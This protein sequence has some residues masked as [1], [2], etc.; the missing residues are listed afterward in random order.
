MNDRHKKNFRNPPNSSN[1]EDL[2]HY[3]WNHGLGN[4][5]DSHGDP[6][7]WNADSM[8]SAFESVH[9]SVDKRAIQNWRS[10]R[11]LPSRR[12]IH[13]LCRIISGDDDAL[14]KL[15]SDKLIASL[16]KRKKTS[17]KKSENVIEATSP[18][19]AKTIAETATKSPRQPQITKRVFMLLPL[20][21]VAIIIGL[22][23]LNKISKSSVNNTPA[24]TG[25]D[26]ITI[27]KSIA[28]FPFKV[29]SDDP[30]VQYFSEGITEETLHGLSQVKDIKLAS[31]RAVASLETRLPSPEAV[32]ATLGVN[33]I[34]DGSVRS[35]GVRFKVSTRLIKTSD[36]SIYWSETFDNKDSNIFDIQEN[37]STGIVTALNIHLSPEERKRMFNFGTRDVEAYR[38]YLKGRHLLKYWH[39]TKKGDDIW[40]A[41]AEFD[42]AVVEDP[43]MSKAW[44]HMADPY[45][46]FAAD[47]IEKPPGSLNVMV[48][49]TVV[50][51]AKHI[52]FVLSKAEETAKN[53]TNKTQARLN[54]IFFSDDWVGLKDATIRFSDLSTQERGELEWEFGPVSL[55]LLG[56]EKRL[57]KLMDDRVLKYDSGNGTAHAYVA[58]SHLVQNKFAAAEN[59]LKT[60]RIS[61]FSSRIN[62]TT[63]YLLYAQNKIEELEGFLDEVS[64]ISPMLEDYFSALI[65]HSKGDSQNA[66]SI[67]LGS[68][69]LAD[70]KIHLALALNHIGQTDKAQKHLKVITDQPL[71]TS[72]L[73]VILSYGAACGSNPLP[74][75]LK[76]DEKLMRANINKLACVKI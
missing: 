21:A 65:T 1:F 16:M 51:A 43:N 54:R 45:Y 40:R 53:E 34:L 55:V 76:L 17:F 23:S 14:K 9:R 69:H 2:F 71:G 19:S 72:M 49:N 26:P 44:F 74:P 18:T 7:P 39:E 28:I 68:K 63:A 25:I 20:M 31:R 61:S 46:H 29:F 52:E 38:H 10:G 36:G 32:K 73:A 50:E 5:L 56:E 6:V 3:I 41:V 70:E 8:E 47:H 57:Q 13:S 66:N 37:I 35:D 33:Y 27:E 42:A 4:H 24:T 30:D 64:D 75:I 62:E 48:P 60:A 59:R 67:L 58:R 11:N 22:V 15:W 12:N